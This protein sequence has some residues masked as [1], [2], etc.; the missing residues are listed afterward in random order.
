M[1]AVVWVGWTT[2]IG[3]G[4]FLTLHGFLF[5]LKGSMERKTRGWN[6]IVLAFFDR[7]Q[8]SLSFFEF[9]VWCFDRR[10]S[11]RFAEFEFLSFSL[12]F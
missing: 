3:W 7:I 1:F 2:N 9:V 12:E 10:R 4:D 5:T 8:G 6:A 11:S